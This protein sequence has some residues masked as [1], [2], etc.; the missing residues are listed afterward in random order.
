MHT[1]CNVRVSRNACRI[2]IAPRTMFP[3]CMPG[4]LQ[5]TVD[6]LRSQ[7]ATINKPMEP[8]MMPRFTSA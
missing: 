4:G 8:S 6:H 5:L 7:Y 3:A 1:T 2:T